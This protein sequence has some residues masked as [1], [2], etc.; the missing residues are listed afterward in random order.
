[1]AKQ[2]FA[3]IMGSPKVEASRYFVLTLVL[4]AAVIV[5]AVAIASMLPLK[6]VVPYM[7][8]SA[9]RLAK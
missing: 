5:M 8:A 7:S 2:E 1:M 3:E 6:R 9:L 4:T